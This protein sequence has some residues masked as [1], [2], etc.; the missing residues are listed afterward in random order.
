MCSTL[1]LPNRPNKL[2]FLEKNS[3]I[4]FNEVLVKS[5]VSQK[6]LGLH[7][8]KKF[9]FTKHIKEKVSKAQKWI[10]VIKR[11]SN[12]LPRNALLTI[13][14]SSAWPHLDYGDIVYDQLN[15]QSISNN[16]KRF[17][18]IL[19][20]QSQKQSKELLKWNSIKN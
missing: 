17:N 12:I 1:I 4:F 20:S 16:I 11:L 2:F 7:L 5:S 10:S 9:D 14:K 18:I 8:D 13:Y 15:K 6:H 3:L 19:P